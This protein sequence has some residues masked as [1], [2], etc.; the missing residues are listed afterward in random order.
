MSLGVFCG[1]ELLSRALVQPGQLQVVL[2][3]FGQT[4]LECTNKN[5]RACKLLFLVCAA[6][7]VIP[8]T[9]LVP[10]YCYSQL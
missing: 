8:V 1:N 4:S 7:I 3:L 2:G 6:V 10:R 5:R 9:I